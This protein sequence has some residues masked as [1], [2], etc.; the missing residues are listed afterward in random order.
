MENRARRLS[1][2]L[3]SRGPGRWPC[4]CC[5]YRTLHEGPGDYDL[6]PV[7]F[8]EDA[9]DQLRWPG[10]ADGPNHISLIDAQHNFDK[11]GAC[12]PES[13]AQVRKPRA[14]EQ[15]EAG[16]RPIDAAVDDFESGPNEP[17]NLPWPPA[18]ELYWWRPTYFRRPENRRPGPAPRR[19]P[20]NRAEEMMARVL[21]AAPET[22]AIDV[23]MRS[24]W[25]EPAPLQFCRELALFVMTAVDSN[26]YELALRVVDVMETG[27]TGGDD[28]SATCVCVGF[29][30]PFHTR[31]TGSST[32]HHERVD[33]VPTEE[34]AAFLDA[35]PP[36]IK[37]EWRRQVAH[38]AKVRRTEE[39]FWKVQ[40][41]GSLRVPYRW[42]L[43]HPILWWKMR[44][45][46]IHLVG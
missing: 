28:F 24:R 26:D 4:R 46:G 13:V 41:D 38:G 43:R 9:G 45:G 25:E 40:S 11:I 1:R 12:H 14:G 37:A 2:H 34:M 19:P 31:R 7:C 30:E 5:G 36:A 17:L 8:W 44:H 3:D 22:E 16:W 15:R 39:K 23:T 35:W 21:A 6:C 29:L 33:Q 18:E 27:L 20:A 10:L 42:K 32:L